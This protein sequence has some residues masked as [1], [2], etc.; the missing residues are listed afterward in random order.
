MVDIVKSIRIFPANATTFETNGYGTLDEA[1]SCQVT[2]ERNGSFELTMKYPMTGRKYNYIQLRNLIVA[3]PNMYDNPQAFRIYR[4]TKPINGIVTI[5][6]CHISYDLSNYLYYGIT[7]SRY[8]MSN[9]KKYWDAVTL[10][11]DLH[12]PNKAANDFDLPFT[13]ETDIEDPIDRG[14][15]YLVFESF[16]GKIKSIRSLLG[17]SDES[18]LTYFD[19][20]YKFDNF[21]VSMLTSRG[22]NNGVTIRYAKNLMDVSAEDNNID[23]YN[24]VLPYW[25]ASD[26]SRHYRIGDPNLGGRNPIVWL[27]E[28][29]D[30][31]KVYPLDLSDRWSDGPPKNG[32]RD[33][34]EAWLRNPEN[35]GIK[36]NI[37]ISFIMLSQS[38]EYK[39]YAVLETVKL[40]DTVTVLYSDLGVNSTTKVVKTTYDCI[41]GKYVSIELGDIGADIS[42]T[43]SS[44]SGG[45]GYVGGN[46]VNVNSVVKNVINSTMYRITKVTRISDNKFQVTGV[47]SYTSG[48]EEGEYVEDDETEVTNTYDISTDSS[49]NTI[50][51]NTTNGNTIT[52]SGW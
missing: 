16:K 49:G 29:R 41:S 22:S 6:A 7:P 1:I 33:A 36:S 17:G 31:M 3:Q 5:D 14:D 2:E 21:A 12:F 19:G 48:S 4:I 11:S 52:F 9:P 13:F 28:S 38:E 30:Y 35:V 47:P 20:E 25:T 32:F 27:G 39:D 46:L 10:N 26:G 43:I 8:W 45:S 34:A 50:F 18:F 44:L 42:S 23:Q 15:S 37:K 40:C 51:T 24:G